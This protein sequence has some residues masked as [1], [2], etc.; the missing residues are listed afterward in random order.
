MLHG[1]EATTLT[2]KKKMKLEVADMKTLEI[3]VRKESRRTG[4]VN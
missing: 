4:C 1:L 2:N 3:F